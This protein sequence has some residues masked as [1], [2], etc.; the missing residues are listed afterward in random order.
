LRVGGKPTV[1]TAAESGTE[2]ELIIPAAHT[3]AAP[4]RR[5]WFAKK[6]SGKS[7]QSKS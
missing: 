5:W 2:I 3:Y 4:P 1:W 7:V 6:F